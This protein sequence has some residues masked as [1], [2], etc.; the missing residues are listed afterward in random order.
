MLSEKG[1]SPNEISQIYS[2]NNPSKR[3]E[4]IQFSLPN[5]NPTGRDAYI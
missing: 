5:A 1:F 3:D 4:S 2:N